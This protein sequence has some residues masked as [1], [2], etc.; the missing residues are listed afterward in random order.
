MAT[1]FKPFEIDDLVATVGSLLA[2]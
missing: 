1:L 2:R